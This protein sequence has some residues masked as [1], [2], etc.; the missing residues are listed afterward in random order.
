MEAIESSELS[1]ADVDFIAK[2]MAQTVYQ[3]LRS[4][5]S[6]SEGI[7]PEKLEGGPRDFKKDSRFG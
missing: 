7:H 5:S 2:W 4:H 1:L 3:N 6:S